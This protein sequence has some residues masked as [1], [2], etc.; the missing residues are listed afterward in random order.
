MRTEPPAGTTP[1]PWAGV[2]LVR[3]ACDVVH[4]RRTPVLHRFRY[5]SP[6]WLVDLDRVPRLPAP[7]RFLASFEPADHGNPRPRACARASTSS[8]PAGG[9]SDRRGYCC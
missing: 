1:G 3:Y 5:R 7:L 4:S 9:G 6:L 8:W 2:A